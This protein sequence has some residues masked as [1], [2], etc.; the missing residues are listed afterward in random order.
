MLILDFR[1]SELREYLCVV[2][3]HQIHYTTICYSSHRTLILW[4]SNCA[5]FCCISFFSCSRNSLLCARHC[6]RGAYKTGTVQASHDGLE[7]KVC[8][9][10]H[11]G[12]P[13]SFP[14]HGT[15]P[16][17]VSGR[18]VV[19]AHIRELERLTTRI[20]NH[21][22]GLWGGKKKRKKKA[23]VQLLPHGML[24][25]VSEADNQQINEMLSWRDKGCVPGVL[26]A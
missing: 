1:P 3:R 13:G 15:T 26:V 6:S 19:V 23:R 5:S 18:A 10:H 20:Y 24:C 22:L 8:H 14:G 12:G 17:S 9:S 7:R 11:F 4:F 16:P 2:L 21:A 25:L